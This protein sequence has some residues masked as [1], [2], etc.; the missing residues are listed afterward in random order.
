M[1]TV[2]EIAD[3]W[4]ISSPAVSNLVKDGMPIDTWEAAEAWRASRRGGVTWENKRRLAAALDGSA[5]PEGK[6]PDDS[7]DAVEEAYL[8]QRD[9][10]RVSRNQYWSAL[11]RD[12][13]NKTQSPQTAKLYATYDKALATLFKIDK[14]RT[15]RALASRQL[16]TRV[17]ALDRFRK[18][19]ALVRDEWEKAETMIAKR[20]NPGNPAVALAALK[21]FRLEVLAKVHSGARE[22]AASI[23][24]QEVGDPLI[25]SAAPAAP[26]PESLEEISPDLDQEP[27]AT[28]NV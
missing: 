17:T 12:A 7:A 18:V 3:R 22:A 9:L 11:K 15:A 20:A 26:R 23:A 4:G 1:P 21:S 14:E 2:S 19:L 13:E 5:G 28:E 24:G 25:D 8:K 10:V 16:I 6:L 27:G